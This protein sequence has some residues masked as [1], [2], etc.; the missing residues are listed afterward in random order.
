MLREVKTRFLR[1]KTNSERSHA[2]H[3]VEVAH[4]D[5]RLVILTVTVREY[6]D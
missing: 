2:H 5:T 4:I 6:H 1:Q 3:G